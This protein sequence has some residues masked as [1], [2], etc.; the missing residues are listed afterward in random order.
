MTELTIADLE[1]A[2]NQDLNFE[3]YPALRDAALSNQANDL[4]CRILPLIPITPG[5]S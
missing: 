2:F 5:H 1:A 3:N 4:E